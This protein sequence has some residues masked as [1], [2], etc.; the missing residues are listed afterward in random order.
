LLILFQSQFVVADT[1]YIKDEIYVPLRG[2][3][4]TEHRIL[5]RGIRS[6]TQLDRLETNDD[7]G[8]T[9]VRLDSGL[10]GWIQSQY[11]S[12]EPIAKYRLTAAQIKLKQLEVD[13]E[14]VRRQLE[15]LESDHSR[16][17]DSNISLQ[18]E[19]T[20]LKEELD[21]ITYLAANVIALDDEN[22]ELKG[23]HDSLLIEID[24]LLVANQELEDTSNQQWFLRGG[25]VI[26]MGLLIGF[27]IARRI[28]HK[29][30]NTGWA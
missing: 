8:Y 25:G 14:N 5:H 19:N 26:L 29:H 24:S 1:V 15:D 13:H 18:G 9:R 20:G 22:D 30:S 11:L 4:S 12:E 27:W 3:Q 2:G 21:N 28:Y 6:G 23:E 16:L 17:T 10:E 7:S